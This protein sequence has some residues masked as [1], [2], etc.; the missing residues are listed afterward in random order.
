MDTH[1]ISIV[2]L[3][4]T[5]LMDILSRKPTGPLSGESLAVEGGPGD[6]STDRMEAH[7][8]TRAPSS[9][10]AFDDCLSKS[11]PD[12]FTPRTP[13]ARPWRKPGSA[14]ARSV[15]KQP[16]PWRLGERW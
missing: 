7:S 12:S 5:E 13:I 4:L 1:P 2:S 8:E 16:G 11:R 9:V 15:G 10:G 14:P 3:G 6:E